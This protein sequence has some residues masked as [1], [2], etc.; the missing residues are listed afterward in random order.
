MPAVRSTVVRVQRVKVRS[1]AR[2]S[3]GG[4]KRFHVAYRPVQHAATQNSVLVV[5]SRQRPH[6]FRI[7]EPCPSSIVKIESRV[8]RGNGYYILYSSNNLPFSPRP[9]VQN[10]YCRT[11]PQKVQRQK[12][13]L[14]VLQPLSFLFKVG[15]RKLGRAFSDR[16]RHRVPS[17][18]ESQN[19]VRFRRQAYALVYRRTC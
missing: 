14:F 9:P 4:V 6:Q 7:R 15:L 13:V 17:E 12:H 2:P 16:T 10:A 3:S 18:A 1:G 11:H 19:H 8:C 5:Q